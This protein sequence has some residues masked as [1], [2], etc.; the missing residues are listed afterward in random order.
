[1]T[2]YIYIGMAGKTITWLLFAA[3]LVMI[4]VTIMAQRQ[5]K[6]ERSNK[7]LVRLAFEKWSNGTGSFF[8]LLDDNMTWTITGRSP[9]ARTYN[10]RRQFLQDAIEPI[11]LRLSKKIV[12]TL[13]ELYAE[14]DMV[15]ALWDGH[16]IAKDGVAYDNTYSWYMKIK[17]GKIVHVVAF[18]DSI[19]LVELWKRNP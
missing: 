18:F 2:N 8:D 19:E 1:M 3:V 13:R 12:P 4:P 9:I 15:I 6:I 16:A 11:N 17:N 10:S 7:E 14:G 5:N